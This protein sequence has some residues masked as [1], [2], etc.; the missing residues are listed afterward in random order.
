M[1][2]GYA[3][4]VFQQ[5]IVDTLAGLVRRDAQGSCFAPGWLVTCRLSGHIGEVREGLLDD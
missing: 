3:L 4:E 1:A 5:E 2:L